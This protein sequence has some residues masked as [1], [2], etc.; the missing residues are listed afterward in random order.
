MKVSLNWLKEYVD[1]N[2]TPDELADKLTRSGTAVE[3]ITYLGE[4]ITG[5][6]T[7]KIEAIEK[8]PEADK[9]WVCQLDTGSGELTQIVTGADNVRAGCIVP[10]A[11]VGST[12]PGGKKMKK[13]KLRGLESNGMLCSASELNIEDKLLQPEERTGIYLLPAD[14]PIGVDIKEILGLDDHVL[15]V[16]LTANRGDCMNMLGMAREVAALTGQK[17]KYPNIK[18]K[19]AG[20]KPDNEII[21]KIEDEQLCQ[22]F[23]ARTFTDINIQPAPMWMKNRLR[24]SGMRPTSNVVDVTNYVML[25]YGQPMHAYDSDTLT[26]NTVI[27]RSS[28]PDE[29][30]ITLDDLERKLTPGMT[31][32]ADSEKAIGLGGVMGGLQTEISDKTKYVFLEAACFDPVATRKTSRALGLASEAS[33]RFV[34]G[35]DKENMLNALDR[36]AQ[37]LEEI[38]AA[39]TVPGKQDVYP[40]KD[41]EKKI[42]TTVEAINSRLGTNIEAQ[43]MIKILESLEF[44]VY[45]PFKGDLTITVPTW[46]NDVTC[47]AD[48][49]EEI[50]RIDGYD[51]ITGTLPAST[52]MQG[53]L[54]KDAKLVNVLKKYLTAAGLNEIIGYSFINEAQLDKLGL[55]KQHPY[56]KAIALSNPITDDF[57][58]MRTTSLP[59]VLAIVE[60]NIARRN[61]DVAVFEVANTYVTDEVPL[62]GFPK[63]EAWLCA[64]LTGNRTNN[65]WNKTKGK[66]DFYDVKGILEQMFAQINISNYQLEPATASYMHPGKSAQIVYK[67]EIIGNVGCLHPKVAKAFNL[68]DTYVIEVKLAPLSNN[69]LAL[70][71]YSRLPKYPEIYR[72][73]SLTVPVEITHEQIVQTLESNGGKQLQ[74]VQLFDL[75]TGK[76]IQQGYKSMSYALTFQAE[77]RTLTDEEVSK[78]VDKIIKALDEKLNIKLR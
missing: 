57:S 73:L 24:A 16:E 5:V 53:Q 72:D 36:A 8:H 9:L 49:S 19:E 56:Y 61:E 48:I 3:Y 40:N 27:A 68:D 21:V 10:V 50:A 64:A 43:R 30:L 26:G 62:K 32:I 41:K 69:S 31:V 23:T 65:D 17:V 76:Q 74:A 15:E 11:T 14:T 29:K 12:L 37:L 46:R 2:I 7:G 58:I 44:K 77:D 18:L 4:E 20:Q 59:S 35:I 78:T 63:E 66:I 45:N 33:S 25:E 60:Y 28:I 70:R 54:S 71:K 51:N 34:H 67:G 52:M 22:R 55:A 13:A 39:K 47:A 38:G 1:I 6:I 75:Y 42:K